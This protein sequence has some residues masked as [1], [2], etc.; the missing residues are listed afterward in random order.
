MSFNTEISW[1]HHSFSMWWGCSKVSP[2]CANCY[3]EAFSRRLGKKVWGRGVP[4][5]RTS[6][7]ARVQPI[8]WNAQ[9]SRR[10][11]RYRV[12]SA[13]MSDVF[14][15]EVPP[16]WREDLWN[17]IRRCTNL[18]W[19]L[20]TKRP[21]NI[22]GMLPKDWGEGWKHV[23]MGTT[24]EDQVRAEERILILQKVPAALRFLSVEPLL[25]PIQLDL[26]GISY[27][28]CGGESGPRYRPMHPDWARSIRDQCI[29]CGI[30][31]HFKQ[32]GTNR[33]KEAGRLLDGR[34]WD[35]F[36]LSPASQECHEKKQLLINGSS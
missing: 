7:N 26:K 3:A 11:L 9:A 35:E 24:V 19:L 16:Q 34:T 18:D 22:L 25:G 20:L 6:E 12:F 30:P 17:L 36:P 8:K 14:D 15:A 31:F 1:T 28:I 21:E 13:S 4:R 27:V 23:W 32:W 5:T 29:A 10:A 33:K 2:A